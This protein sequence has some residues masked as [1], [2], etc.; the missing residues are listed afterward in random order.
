M[1]HVC[2]RSCNT[3]TRGSGAGGHRLRRKPVHDKGLHDLVVESEGLHRVQRQPYWNGEGKHLDPRELEDLD[4]P[5]HVV[6]RLWWDVQRHLRPECIPRG[7]V[8]HRWRREI[9][10]HG[11]V[12]LGVAAEQRSEGQRRVAR[13]PIRRPA[14]LERA[15]SVHVPD[16]CRKPQR[17][18]LPEPELP[19]HPNATGNERATRIQG[20]QRAESLANALSELHAVHGK[21][22]QLPEASCRVLLRHLHH[23]LQRVRHPVAVAVQRQGAH[24]RHTH[25][26]W[27]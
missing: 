24:D 5:W 22:D 20:R 12:A 8:A 27:Q 1:Q 25:G 15:D 9:Q 17:P 11:L 18:A 3:G 4:R 13:Q 19:S 26:R 7:V 16:L 6:H 23:E 21:Q 14:H 10:D 2:C